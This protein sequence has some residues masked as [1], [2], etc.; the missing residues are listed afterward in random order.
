M[1]RLTKP[2]EE[3]IAEIKQYFDDVFVH[4]SSSRTKIYWLPI[5]EGRPYWVEITVKH[6]LPPPRKPFE[7]QEAVKCRVFY[8]ELCLLSDIEYYHVPH[9][10]LPRLYDSSEQFEHWIRY[11]ELSPLLHRGMMTICPY[12]PKYIEKNG[13]DLFEI[14]K[15]VASH[16][17]MFEYWRSGFGWQGGGIPH[18]RDTHVEFILR[19]ALRR[20]R[21]TSTS[22]TALDTYKVLQNIVP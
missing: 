16:L 21:L 22:A 13:V 8:R 5:A 10:W 1:A 7:G 14:M 15:L 20:H 17:A 2:I 3:Q 19:K 18:K 6:D 4:R 9:T 11:G 12:E